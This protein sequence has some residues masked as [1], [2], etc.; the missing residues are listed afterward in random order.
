LRRE[1][2]ELL[3]KA[4]LGRK[5]LLCFKSPFHNALSKPRI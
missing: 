5:G 1:C 4:P 3:P 2:Q